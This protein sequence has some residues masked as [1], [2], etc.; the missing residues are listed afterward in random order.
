MARLNAS[1][2]GFR[3]STL[4][5]EANLGICKYCGTSAGLFRDE[6]PACA[7]K[8]QDEFA[9][10]LASIKEVMNQAVSDKRI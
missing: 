5:G 3:P 7:R 6:H 4:K 8:A 2:V 9:S 1:L 10:A